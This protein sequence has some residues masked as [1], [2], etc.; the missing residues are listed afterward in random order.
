M[1]GIWIDRHFAEKQG[2]AIGETLTISCRDSEF[3]QIVRGFDDD[4]E[5]TNFVIDDTYL[6]TEYGEYC[7]AFLDASSKS[8]APSELNSRRILYPAP[9][10]ST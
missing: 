7:Y 9:S 6:D 4:S 8:E 1:S 2:I 10:V 5:H 3:S